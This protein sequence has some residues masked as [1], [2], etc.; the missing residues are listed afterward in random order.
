MTKENMLELALA[1]FTGYH[2]G[3]R[4]YDISE[5][6][7]SMGLT[8]EEWKKVKKEED[9]NLDEDEIEEVNEYFK[10]SKI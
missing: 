1:Q 10:E 4:G 3:N 5:L 6:V 8:E 9:T 2:L 7:S